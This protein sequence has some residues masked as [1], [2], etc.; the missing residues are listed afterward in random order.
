M[1]RFFLSLKNAWEGSFKKDTHTVLTA[2]RR[3]FVGTIGSIRDTYAR[4]GAHTHTHLA[5]DLESVIDERRRQ[6]SRGII[7]QV[8]SGVI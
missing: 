8:R 7:S 1:I 3:S 2:V 6:V 4:R 5:M